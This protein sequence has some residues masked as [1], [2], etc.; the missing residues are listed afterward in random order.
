MGALSIRL[1]N[2]T[3]FKTLQTLFANTFQKLFKL[4]AKLVLAELRD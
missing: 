1:E 3:R 4:N 2:Q